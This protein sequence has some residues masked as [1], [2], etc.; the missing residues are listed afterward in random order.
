MTHVNFT[1]NLLAFIFHKFKVLE[2]DR[3]AISL[4]APSL[5]ASGSPRDEHP[6]STAIKE[7]PRGNTPW[8]F[9]KVKIPADRYPTSPNSVSVEEKM[10]SL[11]DLRYNI[12]ERALLGG[13]EWPI[14]IPRS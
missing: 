12:F 9:M 2:F 7:N 3:T 8:F 10:L 6:A 1:H 13:K 4:S 14:P 11:K 5:T